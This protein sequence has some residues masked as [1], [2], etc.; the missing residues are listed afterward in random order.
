MKT[1][2]EEAIIQLIQSRL[3]Q[4]RLTAGETIFVTLE[5]GDVV[6][7]GWCDTEKQRIAALRIVTGTYGVRRVI[8]R[9]R[10]RRLAVSI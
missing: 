3:S 9:I 10:V 4:D 2:R 7:I 8:D 5:D 6:L 1:V